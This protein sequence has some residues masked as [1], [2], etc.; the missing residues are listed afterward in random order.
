[1]IEQIK[2]E[3]SPDKKKWYHK[4]RFSAFNQIKQWEKR[5]PGKQSLIDFLVADACTRTR[6]PGKRAVY[7]EY[8][9]LP[10]QTHLFLERA[11]IPM[12]NEVSPMFDHLV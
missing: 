11:F 4:N 3:K 9:A 6:S 10:R 8:L 12:I 1:M 7:L 5:Y 2:V